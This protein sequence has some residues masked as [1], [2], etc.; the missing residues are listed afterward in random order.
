MSLTILIESDAAGVAPARLTLDAARVV[1]GRSASSDVRLPDPSV[2][3]RH[4]IIQASA[5]QYSV[6]DEGSLNG[7]WVGGVRLALR[8]PR[9]LGSGDR[10]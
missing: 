2:S 9:V 4:A 1:L 7:T 3:Q 10:M 5:G 6:L 8:G